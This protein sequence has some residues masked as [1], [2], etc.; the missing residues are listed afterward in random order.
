LSELIEEKSICVTDI[1]A[2]T[3]VDPQELILGQKFKDMVYYNQESERESERATKET[4]SLEKIFNAVNKFTLAKTQ[5]ETP[6]IK[7]SLKKS[8]T[9]NVVC[10]EKRSKFKKF[11]N[12]FINMNSETDINFRNDKIKFNPNKYNNNMLIEEKPDTFGTNSFKI[13][14]VVNEL[15]LN[16]IEEEHKF[17]NINEDMNEPLSLYCL[18]KNSLKSSIN[19]ELLLRRD[20]QSSLPSGF[21]YHEN[22][23]N[24]I[25]ILIVDDSESIC[26]SL[27]KLFTN[28]IEMNYSN[29]KNEF[30]IIKLRDGIDILYQ[31]YQDVIRNKNEIKLILSDEMM[32][33]LNGS[34][35]CTI[36][37]KITNGKKIQKIPFVICSAF[38]DSNHI[39]KMKKININE[40]FAKPL[41]KGNVIYIFEKYFNDI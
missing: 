41:H 26:N 32:E 15:E 29:R 17:D 36:L 3:K 24:Y 37:E 11:K 30:R 39:E 35:A 5:S 20:S 16:V 2:D 21:D 34:E 6:T 9:T 19:E 38:T 14:E 33:F 4:V 25:K 10:K 27:C 22:D 40:S 18:R 28:Y 8:L 31:V 12:S 13:N 7:N 23:T 1:S